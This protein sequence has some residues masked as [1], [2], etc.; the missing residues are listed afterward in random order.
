MLR[1]FIIF[2]WLWGSVF[3]VA[4]AEVMRVTLLGTGGPPPDAERAGP[5]VLVEAGEHKLLFD[6]GRG[7]VQ[8]LQESSTPLAAVDRVFFT[9]LH[10]DHIVG[11]PDL[12]LTGWIWQR[13]DPLRL[14]GP[15]GT[16]SHVV[17]LEQAYSEDIAFRR[18]YTGLS[19]KG[20]RIDAYDIEPGVVFEVDEL[21]VRAF[22]VDH[23]PIEPAFGYLVRY[24]ERSVAISGDTRYSENLI[25]HTKGV[26]LLIHE[27]ADAPPNLAK[28]N[29]RLMKVLDYHTSPEDA[30]R[31]FEAVQPKL[32]VFTH[33][34]LFGGID[35]DSVLKTVREQGYEGEVMM[36]E[37]L[38]WFDVG[39]RVTFGRYKDFNFW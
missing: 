4:H 30:A 13:R 25:K 18:A 11:F 24:G 26:D 32:A 2:L 38:T 6:A 7:V 10:S 39:N 23:S 17:H 14:Y 37:D 34:L 16:V 27:I 21:S 15:E 36:G 28:R 8:R 3:T 31:V 35:G 5:A 22:L 19:P 33:V 12:W 9:H 20:V 1:P 29:K